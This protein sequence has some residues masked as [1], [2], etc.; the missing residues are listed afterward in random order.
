MMKGLKRLALPW[1]S[2]CDATGTGPLNG[3]TGLQPLAR[4]TYNAQWADP[5]GRQHVQADYG[6]NGGAELTRP[7][8]APE[9]SDTVLIT[10]TH[11]AQDG[12]PSQTV[13]PDGVI[14]RT[15]KDRLG[16]QIK[17][18]ENFVADAP[19]TDSGANRTTEYVYAPDG[20]LSRLIVKN[21]VT[22]DQVTRWD[23]GTTLE[24]SGVARTDLLRAK[25]YPGDVAADGTI[26]RSLSYTY[27]RQGRNIGTT[28][29][30]GTGHDFNLD[31]LGQILED[32]V[33]TLGT[34]V[35]GA[36]RRISRAYDARGLV[37][38][39]TSHDD[40]TV[41]AGSV[42][43][44]VVNEYDAFGQQ[45]AD[46]QSHDGAADGSTPRVSYAYADGSANT[47]RRTSVTYPSGK[48]VN[49]SY[50][51]A[52]SIDDRL[53]RMAQT[54]IAGEGQPLA[55]FQWAG[56]GRF[57]RLGMPQPGLEL[58]YHKPADEPVGDSGDPYS[59]YDRFGRTV[60]MRW[61]KILSAESVQ[62]VDRIQYGYDRASRRLWRQ[63]LAAPASAKQDK[64]YQY[65]GLGQVRNANQGNLNINRTAISAIPVEAEAFAYDPIGNW[66]NYQR[67]ED[68]FPVLEQPRQ[69]NQDNQI[70]SLSGIASG[71]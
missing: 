51:A 23:F 13:A 45:T 27:D 26:L 41:G 39:I 42:V 1:V 68:G 36:V 67:D 56:A 71:D 9:P 3:P 60:D 64:F 65:D 70:V 43:N 31:K 25:M 10:R 20:G 24:D 12:Q 19:E 38:S 11:Y 5:I 52:G 37:S 32:R 29:A 14:T 54:Q 15:Q 7:T 30:N 47:T 49:I 33:V 46:I 18:I 34:S 44:Q 22:G 8:L 4:V 40:P 2:A 55:T 57:L 66:Q 61:N 62:S 63:D 50:G 28:D 53:D 58:T 69:N 21:I 48:V 6:T 59:G 35:D 16:R 17:L